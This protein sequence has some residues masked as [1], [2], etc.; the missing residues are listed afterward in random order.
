MNIQGEKLNSNKRRLICDLFKINAIQFGEFILKSGIKS[1]FYIDLRRVVSYP[2]IMKQI[3]KLFADAIS[4]LKFDLITGIPYTALPMASQLAS[5]VNKPLIYPRREVKSYGTAR[6]IEGVYKPGQK[7]LVIDDVM[8]TGESKLEIGEILEESG[9]TVKHFLVLIDRSSKGKETLEDHGYSLTA[10]LS[11]SDILKILEE[12]EYISKNQLNT[13]STFLSYRAQDKKISKQKFL[14][15]AKND[16]TRL[17]FKTMVAKQS[18]LI[19]S[20]DVDNQKDFFDLLE[21]TAD[22]IVMVKTHVDI[23]SDFSVSFIDRLLGMSRDRNFLIFEDRKFADIGNTVQKQFHGGIYKISSWADFITVHMIPGPGILDGLFSEKKGKNCSA[24]LLAAMSAKGNLISENY[25]RQVIDIA[26][27]YEKNIS[28]FI[29]FGNTEKK[30]LKIKNKLPSEML[31]LTP[32]VHL[33]KKGDGLGQQYV[34]LEQAI[35]GG[36]DCIIVGRGIYNDKDPAEKALNYKESAW[37]E[38]EKANF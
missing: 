9:L 24:F 1:P 23:L 34:S 10:I 18:N 26:R 3:T 16:K 38:Y 6:Q 32:G 27:K 28:G 8:T 5:K 21:K 33:I 7:C 2:V 12:E 35:R 20:L 30:L 19:L 36:S 15:N 29:G 25:T 37:Q 22:H 13:V 14:D 4:N 11:I 31:L 17:L